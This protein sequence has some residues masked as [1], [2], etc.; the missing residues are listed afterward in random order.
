MIDFLKYCF[1]IFNKETDWEENNYYSKICAASQQILDFKVPNGCNLSIEKS[2][3]PHLKSNYI[4]SLPNKRSVGFLFTSLPQNLKSIHLGYE[5]ENVMRKE[6]SD[7]P[8]NYPLKPI[9][10]KNIKT[11]QLKS[12]K[13]RE[14][15]RLKELEKKRKE[16]EEYDKKKYKSY[17]LCG[18]L[19]EDMHMEGLFSKRF[20]KNVLFVSTSIIPWYTNKT[21][22]NNQL[23]FHNSRVYNELNYLSDTNIFGYNSLI[24]LT[25]NW[26]A[27]G[28]LYLTK[29]GGGIGMSV[30]ARY[31][32]HYTDDS[33]AV[34]TI[35]SN[36]VMGFIS[37]TYTSSVAKGMYMS[38]RYNFNIYSYNSDLAFGIEYKP[39]KKNQLVKAKISLK[40]GIAFLYEGRY[41]RARY[42]IGFSSG[43][44][45]T[46]KQNIGLEVAFS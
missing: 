11:F 10:N 16:N 42:N 4:I 38:T 28:E 39:Q 3:S 45:K 30:G 27:G 43:F 29:T 21:I 23:F 7:T 20:K 32:K 46:A 35:V 8:P 2:I 22:V 41:Q 18:R 31:K 15:K 36:P 34:F 24:K 13:E 33:S 6:I 25:K 12:Q 44:G 26:H 19:H 17:L 9:E 37:S 1:Q 40:D 5:T 14:L